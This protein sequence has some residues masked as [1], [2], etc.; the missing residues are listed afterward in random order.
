[1]R[2]G[3]QILVDQLVIHGV[4]LAFGVPGESYLAVLD[5][6]HDAPLRLIAT[7]HEA[8]AATMAEAYGKLTG[9]PGICLVTRG[10]GAT[11]ASVGVHTAA[12]DSTPMILLVGQVARGTIGREGFQELDY[13]QVFGPIAKWAT[14][15][16]EAA[17]LPEV[18]ARAFSVACSGRPGPV[19]VALPEDM[20]TEQAD[21]PD[22]VRAETAAAS[23][24]ASELAQLAD[25]LEGARRPLAIVGE[26]GWTAQAGADIVAFARAAQIPVAASFRCQDYVDNDAEVYAGHAGIG[27]ASALARRIAEADLLLAVGGRLGDIPS[28]GYTLLDI[29][30][31]RQR[32]VHVHPDPDE[33]GAVYQPELRI[34]SGL[35]QFASATRGRVRWEGAAARGAL[36]AQARAE[37]EANLR[38]ARR[39]PGEL[40][41][42]EVMAVLRERLGPEAILTCGA[43]NFT[44][45]AHRYYVFRR[46]PS[47]LA[48]RSGSMGYGFPAA[49]AAKAIYP[50]RTVVCLAG[51]GDFLMT[52]QELATAVQEDLA[53]IV[54]VV[55]NGIYGTIRMH[56]E[57]HYPGRVV[58]TDLVNPDFAA[59]ARAFGAHG[60][61]VQ[62]TGEFAGA[63]E[64]A[65]A[66][67]RPALIELKL[68]P[69]AIT[70]SQTLTEI[71]EAAR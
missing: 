6:L 49:I 25:L 62:R 11:H 55:N 36:V 50:D 35:A 52:G 32:L 20:L 61:M 44:V 41:L 10:P 66:A 24:G 68:D 38:E 27:M 39:L 31:P 60:E 9:R 1:M 47:Q 29:P 59:Y 30:R 14:Q 19:V 40:Q 5:A 57:R 65:F 43:G 56:Q 45:W 48:P 7:R 33:L 54:L 8:G 28:S 2:R 17:R 71:R 63:L 15:V 53:V 34:V 67:R 46:F 22:A 12:Q 23:P 37:Y 3:G 64:E 70:P 18:I 58:G 51:D 21:V 26:G 4:A 16:D 13:R 69:E 42:A